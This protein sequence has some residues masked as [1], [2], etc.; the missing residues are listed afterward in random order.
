ML[1]PRVD[2]ELKQVSKRPRLALGLG[3]NFSMP[4]LLDM[5][6]DSYKNFLHQNCG[7]DDIENTGLSSAL[8]SVFLS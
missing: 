4:G 5:Q 2:S 3:E 6:V 7:A 8:S 1:V